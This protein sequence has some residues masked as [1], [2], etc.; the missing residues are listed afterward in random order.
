[1]AIATK[2]IQLTVPAGTLEPL[3]AASLA[4]YVLR[5]SKEETWSNLLAAALAGPGKARDAMAAF[6]L[7]EHQL[8]VL[9]ENEH[10][11]R[12]LRLTPTVQLAMCPE[13]GA[14]LWVEG[15]APNRCTIG[16]ACTGSPVKAPVAKAVK[17]PKP[18]AE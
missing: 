13:C 2:T 6:D 14:A 15:T 4:L 7:D 12:Q 11:L 5:R 17:E 8:D 3:E 18:Q 9:H 10:L 1:M 16:T